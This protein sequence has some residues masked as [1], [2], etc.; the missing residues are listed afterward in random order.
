MRFL[1]DDRGQDLIEYG[2]LISIITAG[3]IVAVNGIGCKVNV[4]FS[5][6]NQ[7]LP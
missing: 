6:A 5:N 4:Y 2:L 3:T 7:A 1:E